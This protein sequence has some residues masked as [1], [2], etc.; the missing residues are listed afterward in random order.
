MNNLALCLPSHLQWTFVLICRK[1]Q[2]GSEGSLLWNQ[3]FDHLLPFST[4]TWV[5]PR[6]LLSPSENYPNHSGHPTSKSEVQLWKLHIKN[7]TFNLKL[8]WRPISKL[9]F[10]KLTSMAWYPECEN[11][12][13]VSIKKCDADV[14]KSCSCHQ[15]ENCLTVQKL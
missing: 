15:C 7:T 13:A 9:K 8:L 6:S 1:P 11:K 10:L 4:G 14:K 12:P 2:L 5:G 3:C